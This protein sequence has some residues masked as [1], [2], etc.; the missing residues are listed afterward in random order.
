MIERLGKYINGNYTVSI[1]EDGTKIRKTEAEDFVPAFA[2]NCDVKITDKC[3]IGC[4]FCY[5]G[6]T[7]TG[8]HADLLSSE[9]MNIINSLYP[10]TEIALNGN[11][12]DHPQL[13]EFLVLLRKKNVLPNITVNEQQF[14]RNFEKIKALKDNDMLFGIGIS[15]TYSNREVIRL[16]SLLKD[17]VFHT[18]AGVTTPEIYKDLLINKCKILI[19]GYKDIKRGSDWKVNNSE[20][21]TKNMSWLKENL[22]DLIAN[23]GVA[24]F[25]NLALEQLDVKSHLTQ[26]QWD[27]FYM[28]DDGHYTFYIDLVKMEY[29]KNSLSTERFPIDGKNID[30]MFQHIISLN[31]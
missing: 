21:Y 2:E 9:A 5:E 24:S 13:M 18:I 27:E 11:D 4:P 23:A 19:L 22:D 20:I 16:A 28:G 8:K 15:Y 25:D 14:M 17:V 12:M 7:P 29:A 31:N 1:Y 10:Y 3:S 30:E 26:K 6:C